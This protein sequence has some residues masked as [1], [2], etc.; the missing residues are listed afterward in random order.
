[1]Y[2]W[3][4]SQ[5]IGFL[6]LKLL[7]ANKKTTRFYQQ[8]NVD[9]IAVSLFTNRETAMLSCLICSYK[10]VCP[11]QW[12]SLGSL[13]GEGGRRGYRWG[14]GIQ[15]GIGRRGYRLQVGWEEGGRDRWQLS[16][17]KPTQVPSFLGSR[18]KDQ[19]QDKGSVSMAII[20]SPVLLSTIPIQHVC[21]SLFVKL[22]QFQRKLIDTLLSQ[23]PFIIFVNPI[24]IMI[25]II[26]S[27]YR[28][29]LFWHSLP[30]NLKYGQP[31]LG[32]STLT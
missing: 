6:K 29:S 4:L 25:S 17:M 1:M 32:E 30:K 9:S 24:T 16:N 28:V 5:D 12:G 21:Q 7:F 10:F 14:K 19:N 26:P 13:T 31:R 2:T 11:Y 20:P 8:S 15:V 22:T 27:L 18:I 23:G 3:A